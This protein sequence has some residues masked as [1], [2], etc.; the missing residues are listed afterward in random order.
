MSC[1]I[2]PAVNLVEENQ[3][4]TLCKNKCG[5]VLGEMEHIHI[6]TKG[7]Q[8]E[9]WCDTCFQDLCDQMKAEGWSHDEEEE[10]KEWC[11]DKCDNVIQE[12]EGQVTDDDEALFLCRACFESHEQ[13]T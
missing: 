12:K 10:D 4:K 1:C 8:E 6:F 13:A 2:A 5:T 7:D 9:T 11:C 3:Y